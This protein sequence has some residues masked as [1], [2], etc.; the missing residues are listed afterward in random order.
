M[1][2]ALLAR[3]QLMRQRGHQNLKG[4]VSDGVHIQL[5]KGCPREN[6]IHAPGTDR[7]SCTSEKIP[8]S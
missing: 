7:A 3:Q 1:I 5:Q 2:D 4:D 6:A 8:L